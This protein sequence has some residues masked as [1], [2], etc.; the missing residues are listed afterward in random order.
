M[1]HAR[2]PAW[3]QRMRAGPLVQAVERRIDPAFIRFGMVGAAG[4]S[5]DWLVLHIMTDRVGLDPFTG[6]LVSFSV[7]VVATWLLN[8]SFTF[9]HQTRHGPIRQAVLYASVQGIGGLANIGAYSAAIKAIPALGHLLVV[10]LAI[11]SAVGL[12]LTF[13]GSK[14]LAFRAAAPVAQAEPS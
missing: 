9:R 13:L 2:A 11:G 6:R 8:R 14:H 4:F 7:A 10:P 12:C 3:V 5:V 1:A